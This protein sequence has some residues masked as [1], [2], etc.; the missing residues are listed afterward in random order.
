[1]DFKLFSLAEQSEIIRILGSLFAK[2]QQANKAAKGILERIDIIK[3]PSSP[4]P[5]AAY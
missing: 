3:K 2:E 4:V 5:S 1:L